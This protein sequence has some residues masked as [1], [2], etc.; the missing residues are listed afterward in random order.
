MLET[1]LFL[2]LRD[3]LLWGI[4]QDVGVQLVAHVHIRDGATRLALQADQILLYFDDRFRITTT[5]ALHIPAT[6][7]HVLREEMSA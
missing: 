2:S 5:V 6:P 3:L 4:L 1:S 7:R